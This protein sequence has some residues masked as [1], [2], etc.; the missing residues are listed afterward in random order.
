ME[1]DWE[2]PVLLILGFILISFGFLRLKEKSYGGRYIVHDIM[3]A[4]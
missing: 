1:A 4:L 2:H 3:E